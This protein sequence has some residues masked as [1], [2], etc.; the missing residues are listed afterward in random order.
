MFENVCGQRVC[1]FLLSR[2]RPFFQGGFFLSVFECWFLGL[3]KTF[4]GYLEFSLHTLSYY[5]AEGITTLFLSLSISPSLFLFLSLHL[6]LF[7]SLSIYISL[8]I[9]PSLS[10]SISLYISLSFC[11]LSFLSLSPHYVNKTKP[12]HND[13]VQAM[14]KY[15]RLNRL[16][17]VMMESIDRRE[18]G[19]LQSMLTSKQGDYLSASYF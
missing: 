15:G 18:S 16:Y 14:L 2:P 4:C 10:L 11:I 5:E 12:F 9:S 17:V 6:F 19:N 1:L 13:N 7:L 8:S 3:F